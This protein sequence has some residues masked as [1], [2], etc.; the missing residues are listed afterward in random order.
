MPEQTPISSIISR[1]NSVRCLMRWAS[2][3][4]PL[5]SKRLMRSPS[6]SRIVKIALRILFSVVT[7]CFAGKTTTPSRNSILFPVNGS[8]RV[9]RSIRSEFLADRQNR[10]THFIFRRDELFRGKNND[11]VEEFDFVSGQRLEARDAFDQ[12]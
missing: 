4:F 1:S 11:A 7:N 10:V 9:M 6:S 5:R 12:I 3:N 2:S 8:K